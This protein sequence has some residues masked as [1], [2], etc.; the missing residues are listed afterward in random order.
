METSEIS[1]PNYVGVVSVLPDNVDYHSRSWLAKLGYHF[2]PQHF[3]QVFL[4][5][6][7]KVEKF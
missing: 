3:V 4:K 1:F 2:T 7:N 6:L 5:I